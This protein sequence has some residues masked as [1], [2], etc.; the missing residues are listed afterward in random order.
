MI[1]NP[2]VDEYARLVMIRNFTP[3]LYSTAPQFEYCVEQLLRDNGLKQNPAVAPKAILNL[4]AEMF[5]LLESL[6]FDEKSQ[7]RF[8]GLMITLM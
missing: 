4:S 2:D 8:G 3:T 1:E 5:A 7:S 6:R